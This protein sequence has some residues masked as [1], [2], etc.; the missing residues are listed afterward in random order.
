MRRLGFGEHGFLVPLAVIIGIVTAGAAV[1]FH[2]LVTWIGHVLYRRADPNFLYGKGVALLILLPAAGGL[3]VGVLSRWIMRMREGH[4]IVDVLETVHRSSGHIRPVMAVEKIVTS[5]ITIGTGGSAGAEGP[6]V[7]IGAAIS[8]GVGQLFQV[9]RAYMPV[10]IGCGTAAGISSIFSSPIGGVLFTLEVILLDFSIRAFTPV[11]VASG[12]AYVTTQAIYRRIGEGEAH[13][14]IFYLPGSIAHAPPLLNWVGVPNMVLLGLACGI[15]AVTLTRAMYV[16]EERFSRVKV[17]RVV[18]PA[19]GGAALGVLGV[20]YVMTFGWLLLARPGDKPIGFTTY[21]MPAF[22]GDGYG[23][24]QAMIGDA[25][26]AQFRPGPLALL[27]AFLIAAK[28]AGTCLTLGS[29]GSGGIIAPSLFLGATTGA[30]L[31]LGLKVAGTNAGLEPGFYALIGMGAVLAAVVHAPL[32]A[33]LILVEISQR[34]GGVILPAM[35]ACVVATGVARLIF[36]DS[37]YT[38]ALRRRGVKVGTGSDLTLLRRLT[39]E[40]VE[41]EPVTAVS[42]DASFQKLLDI[43]AGTGAT[44]FVVVDRDGSYAGMVVADDVKTAL[45]EREAIPLLQVGEMLRPE[46]P[47]VK[48]TDDLATVLETFSQYEV[49]R[50]PVSLA[51]TTGRVIGLISRQGLMRRYHAALTE[52]G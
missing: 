26:Y 19:I 32:A 36:K 52:G 34:E 2:E 21:P 49:S 28:I 50:L 5:A 7:Q 44:D 14:S 22:F 51:N 46:L 13:T 37:I 25:M 8:S 16:S 24:I 1:A 3:A 33:I 18:L 42:I 20:A 48:S 11:V 9:A 12:V 4:G 47:S 40:Q 45:M 6:I 38:L 27:L 43:T 10:L 17:P 35:L 31:G 15:V 30:L 39:V 29:G 23:V 41:L